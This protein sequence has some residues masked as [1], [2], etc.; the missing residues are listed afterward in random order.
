MENGRDH[1]LTNVQANGVPNIGEQEGDVVGWD[2]REDGGQSGECVAYAD[3]TTRDGAI[4]HD[5]NS[6]GGVDMVLDLS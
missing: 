2:L 6:S 4:S 1:I 5:E 3:G